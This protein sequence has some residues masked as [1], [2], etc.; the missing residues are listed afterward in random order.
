[1]PVNELTG[2]SRAL[3]TSARGSRLAATLISTLHRSR[4]WSR[5]MAGRDMGR[6]PRHLGKPDLTAPTRPITV[7]R[8]ASH[9]SADRS[10]PAP[11]RLQR[12]VREGLVTSSS[13]PAAGTGGG[14]LLPSASPDGCTWKTMDRLCHM[15]LTG[16]GRREGPRWSWE[17]RG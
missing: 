12:L 8:D 1:M 4:H 3:G 14:H 5:R 7:S 13:S 9:P 6:L 11:A 16:G 2:A 17:R 15:E 10:V